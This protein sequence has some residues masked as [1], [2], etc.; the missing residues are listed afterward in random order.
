MLTKQKQRSIR[1]L[2]FLLF[3][4]CILLFGS[5][6]IDLSIK[7]AYPFII[8]ALLVAFSVFSKV[9]HSAVA[10]FICGAFADSI[11]SETYCF[12]TIA[13]MLLSVASCLIFDNLFNK[14]LKAAIFLCFLCT[15]IYYFFYFI[16]F[17]G[18]DVNISNSAE[19]LLQYALPSSAYTAVFV[20]P[21]YFIYKHWNRL[22]NE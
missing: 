22:R 4:V 19:Y 12:N 11:A 5:A 8:L 21:F 2:S 10:G 7:N 15:C 6:S 18:P 14:N 3:G 16:F 9:S 20:I 13:L 17:I 1:F